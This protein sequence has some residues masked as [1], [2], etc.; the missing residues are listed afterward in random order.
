VTLRYARV[1]TPE[2]IADQ[3][4]ASLTAAAQG[5]EQLVLDTVKQIIDALVDIAEGV[6]VVGIDPL[7]PGTTPNITGLKPQI[8]AAIN[9]LNTLRGQLQPG[10]MN[11]IADVHQAAVALR[12]LLQS[13]PAGTEITFTW[14]DALAAAIAPGLTIANALFNFKNKN[15][16]RFRDA[17][18]EMR[19]SSQDIIDALNLLKT[20]TPQ[21]AALGS[22]AQ[23]P[24]MSPPVVAWEYWNGRRWVPLGASAATAAPGSLTFT[25]FG[26]AGSEITFTVPDDIEPSEYSGVTARWIRARL[27]AGGYG[28]V[29]TVKWKDDQG[30][31]HFY[32]IIEIRPPNIERLRLGYTWRSRPTPPERTFTENDFAFTDQTDAAITRGT[33][34]PPFSPVRDL[35]PTL[36]LGFDAPLPADLISLFLDIEEIVGDDEG[37]T[38]DWEGW[39]G[40][41]WVPVRERDDTRGLAVPGMVALPWPGTPSSAN[42]LLARFGTPLAWIRARRRSDGSPRQSLVRGAFLNAAWASEIRS[43]DGETVGGGS[44][45]PG[46]SFRVRNVPILLGES[47]EVRELSGPRA[48]VEEPMLREELL[49]GR[50]LRVGHSSGA[51]SANQPDRRGV[52]PLAESWKPAVRRP[53]RA[54]LRSGADPRPDPLRRDWPPA[55][56]FP[57]GPTTCG[58]PAIAPA[59]ERGATWGARRSTRF[60]PACSP[61]G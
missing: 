4:G 51:R 6:I 59:A 40:E 17:E 49:P 58:S 18:T 7:P 15:D 50:A 21:A 12:N 20:M 11:L 36:Y 47:L 35:S 52:G 57:R 26:A 55:A 38:L 44:G 46:Q 32:P 16:K 61:S 1:R 48:R 56:P 29:T 45:E 27:T 3:Q 19:Q 43:Y 9:T 41:A 53:G 28:I 23:V 34:F 2:E 10:R 13:V 14:L 5:A 39:N 22:G 33:P 31:I 54:D 8:N 25:E 42:P 37:P 60:S 30:H 24:T